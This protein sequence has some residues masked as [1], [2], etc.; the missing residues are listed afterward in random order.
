MLFNPFLEIDYDCVK[1]NVVTIAYKYRDSL[2]SLI[3]WFIDAFYVLPEERIYFVHEF[4]PIVDPG[5]I[6]Y[7]RTIN[8]VLKYEKVGF[9][10]VTV[11]LVILLVGTVPSICMYF[12]VN[13]LLRFLAVFTF[14]TLKK[15]YP[16][17]GPLFYQPENKID[18]WLLPKNINSIYDPQLF[19]NCYKQFLFSDHRV[20][21]EL[22][23]RTPKKLEIEVLG[24]P[25]TAAELIKRPN[26][27]L[28]HNCMGKFKYS[29]K[30][31]EPY[32]RLITPTPPEVIE[33]TQI[34]EAFLKNYTY[35]EKIPIFT[36]EEYA[37]IVTKIDDYNL[38]TDILALGIYFG[39]HIL[40][41][42]L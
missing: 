13:N 39:T 18:A 41:F 34:A 1:I 30:S 26:K 6:H 14:V 40:Y 21:K 32:Q 33:G 9:D 23:F 4:Q 12:I 37:E 19:V 22:I 29:L 15:N 42:F 35:S 28:V 8:R 2:I 17:R 11:W 27:F 16:P 7:H 38:L 3:H 24:L 5:S 36:P 25:E 31:Q 20:I 10:P